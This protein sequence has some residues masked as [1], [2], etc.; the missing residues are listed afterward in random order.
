MDGHFEVVLVSGWNACVNPLYDIK[1]ILWTT[2]HQNTVIVMSWQSGDTVFLDD[3]NVAVIYVSLLD[4][5]ICVMTGHV[6]QVDFH[7]GDWLMRT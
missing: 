2:E 6:G 5:R 3:W 7:L 1:N 4:D